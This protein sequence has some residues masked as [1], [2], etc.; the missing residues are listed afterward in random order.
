M[1]R[2][3]EIEMY[4]IGDKV[5]V[6]IVGEVTQ[7]ERG[8]RGNITYQVKSTREEFEGVAYSLAES[9]ISLIEKKA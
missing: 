4:Q 6:T 7:V 3:G 5:L 1:T 2:G 9:T 8:Y